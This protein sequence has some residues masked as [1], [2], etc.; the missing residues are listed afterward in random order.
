MSTKI[1]A[2]RIATSAGVTTVVTR[3]SS[4]ANISKLVRYI[5]ATKGS[6]QITP[7]I[8]GENILDLTD[9]E[10]AQS[11]VSL[12]QSLASF[13]IEI[14][15]LH[16]RFVPDAEPVRD[17][18]FWVLHG[19]APHG[20]LYIDNGAHK[21]LQDKAGLLPI[22]IVDVEGNFAQHEAVR[23]VVV[24]RLSTP[25][26]DG[27]CYIGPGIEVGRAIVNY[28][29]PE[30]ARIKGHKSVD[31]GGLLGYADSEYVAPRQYIS[32]FKSVSRPVT[33]SFENMPIL[34][35]LT[36]IDAITINPASQR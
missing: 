24:D 3:A 26:P 2:A 1:V 30:V 23:L 25:G 35:G 5:E 33:P 21:A 4:P 17:R 12:A 18:H 28:S 36:T 34:P 11:T 16:T 13:D 10:L 31:I 20:T 29:A 8:N 14:P 27:K 15:P 7:V 32:F 19:L 6:P 9:E 22:G